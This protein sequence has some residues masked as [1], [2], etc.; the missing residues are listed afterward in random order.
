[1]SIR[2]SSTDPRPGRRRVRVWGV[3]LTL[4]LALAAAPL[5]AVAAAP[6]GDRLPVI[7]CEE[8]VGTDL[9]AVLGTTGAV[10]AAA[11]AGT[12]D[13]AYCAVSIRAGGATEI[14]AR[15]PLQTWEGRYLQLG[16]GGMCGAVRFAV[17]PAADTAFALESNSFVVAATNEGHN[18]PAML[19]GGES[20]ELRADYGY[21]AN[22]W[23]SVA[24]EHLIEAFY[25]QGADFS[26]FTG[27]SDGG[28]AAIVEA[29]RYPDDF[30]GIL[31]GAPAIYTSESLTAAFIW[32]GIWAAELDDAARTVLADA[33]MAVCDPADGVADGQISDPRGC[34]VDPET[35][36]CPDGA[37][38]GCLSAEQADAARRLYEGP[39]TEEGEYLHPGGLPEG[40]ERNWP[41]GPGPVP[42]DYG[43]YL[44]FPDP[45]D[46]SWTW[47]DFTF[48][49]ETY[50]ALQPMA[51][52]YNADNGKDPDLR[53]FDA[54]GGKL[55]VWYG[56]ADASTGQDSTLDWYAQVQE[57]SGGLAATQEFARLYQV[58]GLYHGGG[59]IDY[60]LE[61][62]PELIRWV[63][64]QEAPETVMATATTPVARTY[65]LYPYPDRA[66][67]TGVGDVTDAANWV[68]ESPPT[69][70]VDHF[71]WLGNPAAAP[72]AEEVRV[73]GVLHEGTP[74]QVVY[75]AIRPADWNGTLILDLDFNGWPAAQREYFLGQGYAIG[76]NQRTQN[77]TAYELKD[78]VDNLV[79][80]RDLLVAAVDATGQASEPSRVIAWGN[81]RGG[82]VARMAAQYRPDVFAGA[83]AGAGGGAGVV[84]TWLGK[85]DAV[86]ALQRLVNPHAGLS[87]NDLPD[88]PAGATY[89]PQYE[90]DVQLA[91]LV[92][93]ASSSD[94]GLA[95]IVL[96]GAF[97]QITDFPT[98]DLPPAPEDYET[99]G[100]NIAS[101]F[102]FGNPQFVHKEIE[103]MSGGP[104]V[105]N[106]GVDYRDLLDRS[107]ARERVEWWY[108]HAGLDLDADLDALN[109]APRYA[110]DPAAI[111]TVEQIGTYT[112]TGSPVLT[113]KTTGDPAD[114]PSLDEAYRRTFTAS[115]N[116]DSLL[117]TAL[118]ERSRH[119]GQSF[120]ESIAAFDALTERLDTGVWPDVSPAAMNAR[121]AALALSTGL[122]ADVL[123][124]AGRYI[125][126]DGLAPALRT[127]DVTDWGTYRVP[128][129]EGG[130]VDPVP[131]SASGAD[132][133]VP[134]P[135]RLGA[136]GLDGASLRGWALVGG[137]LLLTGVGAVIFRRRRAG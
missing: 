18:G 73:S 115:G 74:G 24:V 3:V 16:C 80:T 83:L 72:I 52:V 123:G 44:A 132:T 9:S 42:T 135:G 131:G 65:P 20:N 93:E 136:T 54:S 120:G 61:L 112:G 64:Q 5:P 130:G 30:D 46:E 67:F 85:A 31:A 107:G 41:T 84:A 1:M 56:L 104:V 81:S 50:D 90:E 34:D 99:Q 8:L 108:A 47:E 82:F 137:I 29:Q 98:G 127:W 6:S 35:L 102:A 122:P 100:R 51:R 4:G 45:L 10:S 109:A 103:V 53:G 49:R 113:I 2:R 23:T 70:P 78:Y 92:N 12:G 13:A 26:Y 133:A 66:A 58:P 111:A 126:F 118:I 62:L 63:E 25:G 119:N 55:L 91:A 117:R 17:S 134:V 57:R 97:E 75:E 114:S 14:E 60:R 79:T 76:G 21:R 43:R 32:R 48:T 89:G 39:R 27:Y 105:W 110:A 7:G 77:E 36:R 106:H 88:I 22:H 129:A 28:R 38:A 96:A 68:R 15:M 40:S 124:G 71:P 101:T 59:Y 128:S 11:V 121:V 95:R 125:P 94:A 69:A 86:W 33:A 87:I 19:G 116:A 37:S